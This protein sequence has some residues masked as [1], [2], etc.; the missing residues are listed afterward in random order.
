MY[1]QSPRIPIIRTYSQ[2]LT[3]PLYAHTTNL[4]HTHYMHVFPISSHTQI[5]ISAPQPNRAPGTTTNGAA[6]LSVQSVQTRPAPALV[7]T[8]SI[9]VQHTHIH[10]HIIRPSTRIQPYIIPTSTHPHSTHRPTQPSP[11]PL[12]PS[13]LPPPPYPTLP[14]HPSSPSSKVLTLPRFPPEPTPKRCKATPDASP[15]VQHW[16][17]GVHSLSERAL[18]NGN[19]ASRP[20]RRRTETRRTRDDRYGDGAGYVSVACAWA[21]G[22][23][24][25]EVETGTPPPNVVGAWTGRELRTGQVGRYGR[26]AVWQVWQVWRVGS[27]VVRYTPPLS[28]CC[29]THIPSSLTGEHLRPL[30]RAAA[31]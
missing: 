19:A 22:R 16:P 20:E 23:A 29:S 17:A 7:H 9:L 24:A 6:P 2:S 14:P 21:W 1:F 30:P 27:R 15:S 8:S 3:Y 10:T 13:S 31:P 18:V 5:P 26:L 11:N 4:L 25:G 28:L 12:P